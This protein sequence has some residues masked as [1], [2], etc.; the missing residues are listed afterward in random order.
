MSMSFTEPT[1]FPVA[2][3]NSR[4]FYA[5]ALAR[6]VRRRRAEL[7]MTVEEAAKLAGM[8][9]SEW[10]ALEAGWVPSERSEMRPIAEVLETSVSQISVLALICRHAQDVTEL[11][12]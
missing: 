1:R 9:I 10:L 12:A 7:G 2:P 4:Q 3:A 6:Y 11:M 5:C 8:Q